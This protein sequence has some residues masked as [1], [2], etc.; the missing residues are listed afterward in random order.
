MSDSTPERCQSNSWV[1]SADVA[2]AVTAVLIIA[3]AFCAGFHGTLPCT[4][5]FVSVIVHPSHLTR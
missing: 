5:R 3:V 1:V 2:A 4:L